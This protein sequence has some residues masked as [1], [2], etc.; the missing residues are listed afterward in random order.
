MSGSTLLTDDHVYNFR[1]LANLHM[2]ATGTIFTDQQRDTIFEEY[3]KFVDPKPFVFGEKSP[4][5]NTNPDDFSSIGTMGEDEED[6][7]FPKNFW[8]G[9]CSSD[10]N[11]TSFV[12]T[13]ALNIHEWYFQKTF[14]KWLPSVGLPFRKHG[15][16][17]IEWEWQWLKTMVVVL[18]VHHNCAA[19]LRD[20]SAQLVQEY[21]EILGRIREI[22]T[23][24]DTHENLPKICKQVAEYI[25]REEVHVNR[26]PYRTRNF[27]QGLFLSGNVDMDW[28]MLS[29]VL[30]L[31]KYIY[32]TEDPIGTTA[33]SLSCTSDFDVFAA[34]IG[35]TKN[36]DNAEWFLRVFMAYHISRIIYPAGG[37]S[38]SMHKDAVLEPYI[39]AK[40]LVEP[41]GIANVNNVDEV[42]S[43]IM[44][45]AA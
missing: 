37:K 11:F 7:D 40:Q 26:T 19:P 16:G 1:Y 9:Y 10:S 28:L 31:E 36:I 6:E 13:H 38:I 45:A 25:A 5:P 2:I 34:S 4:P 22:G 39:Y 14:Q 20:T 15:I 17:G 35:N 24:F 30:D 42:I 43:A 29:D 27:R 18:G 8:K 3:G 41:L 32:N 12:P 21:H 44:N 23:T 33:R